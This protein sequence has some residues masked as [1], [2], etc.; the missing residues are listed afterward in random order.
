M[1]FLKYLYINNWP[2]PVEQ[3]LAPTLK[4]GQVAAKSLK[5]RLQPFRL[6]VPSEFVNA[7]VR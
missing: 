7:S 6:R 2:H 1:E 5:V 3:I 4:K